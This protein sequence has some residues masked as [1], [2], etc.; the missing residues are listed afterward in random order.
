MGVEGS[1]AFAWFELSDVGLNVDGE[2]R[3]GSSEY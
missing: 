1:G 3:P 2:C